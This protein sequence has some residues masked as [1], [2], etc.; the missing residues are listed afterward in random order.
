[1][2]GNAE[3]AADKWAAASAVI[4]DGSADGATYIDL[5]VPARPAVGGIGGT[6]SAASTDP[7]QLTA[8]QTTGTS[9]P[10]NTPGAVVTPGPTATPAASTGTATGA[11]TATGTGTTTGA[12]TSGTTTGTGATPN[13]ATGAGGTQA[14]VVGAN[15]GTGGAAIGATP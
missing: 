14:P 10:L 2:F 13:T 6:K 8:A 1:V 4:A 12:G 9:L 5:R 3:Q 7:P 15:T 11:G